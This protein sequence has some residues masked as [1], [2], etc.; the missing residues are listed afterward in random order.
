MVLWSHDADTL[1]IGKVIEL[2]IED[3]ALKASVQFVDQNVPMVGEK[4]EA[5]YQLLKN[6]YLNATSVGF[7]VIDADIS[8]RMSPSGRPGLDI[9][10]AELCEL[11][12]VSI[13]SN[14]DALIEHRNYANQKDK[15]NNIQHK[16]VKEL[17][18]RELNYIDMIEAELSIKS[19]K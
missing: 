13:P 19:Y 9:K 17:R 7:A 16:Y 10:S 15:E 11:S 4:A 1:P 6:G 3:A 2:S 8:D 5:I 14:P 18:Q 12:I